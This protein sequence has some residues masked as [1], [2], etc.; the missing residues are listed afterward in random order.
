VETEAFDSQR[1][2][3]SLRAVARANVA[4]LEPG[5]VVKI[6][7]DEGD[8]VK[9]GQVLTILDRRRIDAEI[10]EARAA[11]TAAEVLVTQR[12]AE[13]KRGESDFEMKTGLFEKKAVSQR[14]LLDSEREKL[15]TAA[16]VKAADDQLNVAKSRLDLLEVRETDLKILAPFDGR[17]V[18]RHIEPGEWVG[19]GEPV[20]SLVSAGDIEAWLEVP[21]RFATS[22]PSEPS[23]LKVFADGGAIAATAK[24]VQRIAEVNMR[25]RIFQVVATIDDFDGKLIHGMSIYADL[26]VGRKAKMLTIPVDGVVASRIGEFIYRVA[27]PPAGGGLPIAEKVPVKVLFRRDGRAYLENEGNLN[28]GDKVVLE[29]N[30]R[31][32]PGQP[33]MISKNPRSEGPKPLP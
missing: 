5:A 24:A 27:E 6:L 9:E 15:V 22:V 16:Q 33:L 18:E 10:A 7:V 11:I 4:A 3:G 1:V 29:G 19:A 13:A 25:S 12:K 30:E 17:V 21:E 8:S 31:L 20:V 23:A 26:P 2:T 32:R 14:E 28:A